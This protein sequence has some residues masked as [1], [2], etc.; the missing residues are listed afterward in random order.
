MYKFYIFLKLFLFI[1]IQS[2]FSVTFN[3]WKNNMIKEAIKNGI[4]ESTAKKNLDSIKKVNSDVLAF[5]NNQPEFKISFNDYKE[6]NISKKRVEKGKRLLKKNKIIFD[7]IKKVYGIP[8]EIILAIWALESN[9][10]YYTGKFNIIDALSTLSYQSRRKS[11]FKNELICALKILDKNLTEVNSLKGSWAGAMGQSQFMPSSYLNYAVDYNGDNKID[12]WKSEADVFASIANYL[13]KHNWNSNLLWSEEVKIKDEFKF[14]SS[15][16][17]T[18]KELKKYF[19]HDKK[20]NIL[21]DETIVKLKVIK[22]KNKDYFFLIF[23]NFNVI[24]KYNNSDYYALTIG[25][26]ANLINK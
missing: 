6:R 15:Q 24:K 17:Y 3:E 2:C 4:S 9:Y 16:S 19:A 23:E 1:Q 11:F 12:I 21:P 14:N 5:Y 20:I 18:L 26:L 8:P 13:K 25:S 22:S 7:K 10:G